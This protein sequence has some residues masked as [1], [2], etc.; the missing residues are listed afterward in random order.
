MGLR[1]DT[2]QAGCSCCQLL[3][4]Q[5]GVAHLSPP[6]STSPFPMGLLMALPAGQWLFPVPQALHEWG[7]G[8]E[9][10]EKGEGP[11]GR[12]GSPSQSGCWNPVLSPS[13]GPWLTAPSEK[14]AGPSQKWSKS[15]KN[16]PTLAR[17]VP[18]P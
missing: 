12:M 1:A 10:R 8:G 15:V 17:E 6:L 16:P 14:S 13:S 5:T 9:Q 18:W 2:A 7:A 3:A 4:R 11:Q